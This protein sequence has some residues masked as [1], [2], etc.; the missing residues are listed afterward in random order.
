M[1]VGDE[2]VEPPSTGRVRFEIVE[3]LMMTM[4]DQCPADPVAAGFGRPIIGP[5]RLRYLEPIR[6]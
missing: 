6:G 3:E 2:E 5:P 1:I 4:F